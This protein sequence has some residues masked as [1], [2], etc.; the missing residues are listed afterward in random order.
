M[1]PE[2]SAVGADIPEREFGAG[3]VDDDAGISGRAGLA[4][5]AVQVKHL[6][7]IGPLVQVVNVLGDDVNLEQLFETGQREVTFVGSGIDD[8]PTALVVEFQDEL[9]MGGEAFWR[10]YFLNAMAFPRPPAPRNVAI[11]DSALIPAP[12]NTTNRLG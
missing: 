12:L 11:P 7:A 10:C 3:Q 1:G 2:L 6:R 8:L 5:F 4:D 9:R